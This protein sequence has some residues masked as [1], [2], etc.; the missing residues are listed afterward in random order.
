[1]TSATRPAQPSIAKKIAA[2]KRFRS[3]HPRLNPP[4]RNL[5]TAKQK[6]SDK[7]RRHSCLRSDD[8]A[9]TISATHARS[10]S[11]AKSKSLRANKKASRE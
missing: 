3:S 4:P 2:Q 1:M 9:L 6:A 8:L 7:W 10:A 5:S 11:R